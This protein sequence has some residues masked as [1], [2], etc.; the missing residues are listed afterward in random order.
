[1]KNKNA[2]K[3]TFKLKLNQIPIRTIIILHHN[4]LVTSEN[5]YMKNVE[6]K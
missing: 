3:N 6:I 4:Y 5:T 2:I 1:M